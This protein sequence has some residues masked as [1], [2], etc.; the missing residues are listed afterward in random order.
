MGLLEWLADRI[1]GTR[2]V[3]VE[4]D[5]LMAEF[6]LDDWDVRCFVSGVRVDP[7]TWGWEKAL[8]IHTSG[9]RYQM[10]QWEVSHLEDRGKLW[11]RLER[12]R[13][14]SI[15]PPEFRPTVEQGTH[16]STRPNPWIRPH[17]YL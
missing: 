3:E 2:I 8:F 5:P 14:A 6:N 12:L 13:L 7:G 11:P 4:T 10:D 17:R 16:D 15:P 1:T 9:F